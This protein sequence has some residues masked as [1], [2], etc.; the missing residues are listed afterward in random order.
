[1]L[2]A[3][4]SLAAAC[5]AVGCSSAPEAARPYATL[6]LTE[7]RQSAVGQLAL[8]YDQQ[9]PQ[10]PGQRLYLVDQNVLG[11]NVSAA[12]AEIKAHPGYGETFSGSVVMHRTYVRNTQG[13]EVFWAELD[14]FTLPGTWLPPLSLPPLPIGDVA[15]ALPPSFNAPAG[16]AP[17]PNPPNS[18]PLNPLVMT[19]AFARPNEHFIWLT[20]DGPLETS[21][22]S[23][24]LFPPPYGE[25]FGGK[26]E[27]V[28]G[29]TVAV[30]GGA[31]II[32]GVVAL[33]ILLDNHYDYPYPHRY[34]HR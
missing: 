25:T 31:I 4:A 11:H 27:K 2:V 24:T 30:V 9:K 6:Q 8:V 10:P 18:V 5:F 23:R 26:A 12:L 33:D 1:M 34:A 14:P 21:V 28:L 13:D 15:Q 16:P 29:G 3:A 20:A 22:P 17:A 7:I 32:T 19:P